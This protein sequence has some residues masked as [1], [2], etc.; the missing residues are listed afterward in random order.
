M[1]AAAR[2]SPTLKATSSSRNCGRRRSAPYNSNSDGAARATQPSAV[3]PTALRSCDA[4]GSDG[5]RPAVGASAGESAPPPTPP[6]STAVARSAA[7]AE[8]ACARDAAVASAA[9]DGG[10]GGADSKAAALSA[11]RRRAASAC[12]A[13]RRSVP[14]ASA[15]STMLPASALPKPWPSRGASVATAVAPSRALGG[16]QTSASAATRLRKAGAASAASAWPTA[17]AAK[18]VGPPTSGREASAAARTSVP[19][20]WEGRG[21][22]EG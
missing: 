12:A 2:P 5:G 9:A 21:R 20:A 16:N 18:A 1:S 17:T 8:S 3:S 22:R 14:S 10:D 19:I 6:R 11:A 15:P 4:D 7:L 13:R